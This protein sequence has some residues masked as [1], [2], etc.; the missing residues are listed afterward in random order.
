MSLRRRIDSFGY[1]FKGLVFLFKTQAN[2][3]IH[4][5]ATLVVLV[6]GWYFEV[7]RVEWLI[8]LLFIVLVIAMEAVNTALEQLTDLVS[9]EWHP[10]AGRAKDLAAAAVF[11]L[12]IGAIFA[13]FI[14]FG[15]KISA[16]F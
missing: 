1:A 2:A 15:P 12:A 3:R 11:V 16:C 10:L 8:L 14:I 7:S 5:L 4:L 13:A 9:P 6:A